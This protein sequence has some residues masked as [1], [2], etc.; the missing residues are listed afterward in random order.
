MRGV[1]AVI[2]SGEPARFGNHF[3]G[4]SGVELRIHIKR[5]A[6]QVE[7]SG[8]GW[9]NTYSLLALLRKCLIINGAGEG[10]RTLVSNRHIDRLLRGHPNR[11]EPLDQQGPFRNRKVR[12]DSRA[13]HFLAPRMTDNFTIS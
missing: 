4:H 8:L 10:N 11:P 2:S 3:P 13:R 7:R 5:G 9:G 6:R 1:E 12:F